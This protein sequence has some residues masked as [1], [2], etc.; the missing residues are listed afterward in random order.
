[1][2]IFCTSILSLPTRLVLAFA[3]AAMVA[4]AGSVHA[5]DPEKTFQENDEPRTIL[6]FGFQALKKGNMEQAIGAFR[7]GASK[8]DLASQ[9]KLARMFQTGSGMEK[10]HLAAY[11]LYSKIA[12]RYSDRFPRRV[13]MPYVAHAVVALGRYNL[14]GI[15]GTRIQAD[16]WRAEAHFYR[17]AALYKDRNAQY[18]L[19]RLYR[20]GALGVKQPKSAVRWFGLSAR[21]G[22]RRAQAELGEMLFYGEGVRA[23]PVR[24][25]VFMTK[26]MANSARS[27]AQSIRVMQQKAFAKASAAQRSAANKI[28]ESLNLDKAPDSAEGEVKTTRRTIRSFFIREERLQNGGEIEVARGENG[29]REDDAELGSGLAVQ[30]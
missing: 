6:R 5:F 20:Q 19:G 4:S 21:K 29:D 1:M 8:N 2:R 7:F 23:N 30:D 17:A 15:E 16:P 3:L 28:I 18:E 27:S 12:S 9:W 13:D 14:T 10:D 25:L 11:Q 22:H 26:A 24:G